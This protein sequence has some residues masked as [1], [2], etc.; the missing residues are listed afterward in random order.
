MSD[1][2]IISANISGVTLFEN[3]NLEKYT[4]MR[5]VVKG[6]LLQVETVEALTELL[7]ELSKIKMKQNS[8]ANC[9]KNCINYML[10]LYWSH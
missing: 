8:L 5:L 3:I 9:C 6:N 2:K 7:S 1:L 10:R 4:T